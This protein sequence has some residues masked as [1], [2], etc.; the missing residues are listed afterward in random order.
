MSVKEMIKG[1]I[2][3]LPDN[4]AEEVYD[5]I[6]FLESKS[7]KNFIVKSYQELSTES[8]KKIWNNEEDAIYDKL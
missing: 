1:E 8:F 5:F 4:L 2:D 7:E 6:L 3:R